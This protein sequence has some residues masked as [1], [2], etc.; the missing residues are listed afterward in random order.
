MAAVREL[1]CGGG[2]AGRL[3]GGGF[4]GYRFWRFDDGR[5]ASEL[6]PE[7]A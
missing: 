1:L 5:P 3:I 4:A 6:V 2:H 7:Q